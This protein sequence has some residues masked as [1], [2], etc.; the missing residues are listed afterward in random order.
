MHVLSEY[1]HHFTFGRGIL[2]DNDMHTPVIYPYDLGSSL[3]AHLSPHQVN[4]NRS[5]D[6]VEGCD[7]LHTD[8]YLPE[9][10]LYVGT[11]DSESREKLGRLHA[12]YHTTLER[13]VYETR[14]QH[15]Y[16]F[17]IDCHALN[18]VAL[19]NTPDVGNTDPR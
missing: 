17:L 16:A 10:P 18:S 14:E 13:M 9:D 19:A 2:V 6:I 12:D 3:I 11:W 15:G 1:E 8:S 4:Y 5:W 7:P